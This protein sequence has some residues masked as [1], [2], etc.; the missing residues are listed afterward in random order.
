VYYWGVKAATPGKRLVGVEVEGEDG[1]NPIGI[2]RA[3]IRLLGYALSGVLLGMGFFIVAFGGTA[4]HD[5]IAGTR[6]VRRERD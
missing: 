2:S 5:R 1:T 3:A 4:L 6:V